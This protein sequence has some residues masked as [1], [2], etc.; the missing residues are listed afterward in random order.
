MDMAKIKL[1][2]LSQHGDLLDRYGAKV[3]ILGQT[4]LLKPDVLEAMNRA[5]ETTA[6]NDRTILNIC[7]PYTSRD[8][9]A[10]A[11]RSTVEEYARPTERSQPGKTKRG[12]FTEQR[13]S[14]TVQSQT[15][16]ESLER[17]TSPEFQVARPLAKQDTHSSIPIP[18]IQEEEDT[19][20]LADD[21]SIASTNTNSH[22]QLSSPTTESTATSYTS[23]P[24]QKPIYDHDPPSYE[25]LRPTSTSSY[26]SVDTITSQTITNHLFTKD[27]PPLDLLVRTSGVERLSDFML[28]QCHETTSIVFLDVLWPEFD[29]W[30]FLPVLWEWQWRRR[31]QEQRELEGQQER[32]TRTITGQVE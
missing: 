2:Q 10:T 12:P 7:F 4:N 29:L 23:S 16:R 24:Q 26:P 20:D 30:S 6:H 1:T 5:V 17:H 14:K 22:A 13:I 3:R 25:T 32:I 28:W 15:S 19:P 21:S 27:D 8:E 31:K 11:V 18:S 9:I